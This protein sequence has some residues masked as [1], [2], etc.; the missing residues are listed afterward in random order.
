MN[1][2]FYPA[3]LDWMREMEQ[4]L[5]CSRIVLGKYLGEIKDRDILAKSYDSAAPDNILNVAAFI[6]IARL[7]K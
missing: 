4:R 3:S 7:R 1:N 6:Y 5:P 2:E